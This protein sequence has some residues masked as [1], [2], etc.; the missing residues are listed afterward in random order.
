MGFWRR[1]IGG[2]KS[3]AEKARERSAEAWME[4]L[5]SPSGFERQEAVEMLGRLRHAVALPALLARLNDWVPQVRA[6]A[7]EAVR[8]LMEESVIDAWRLSLDSVVALGRARRV[9]HAELLEEI[10]EFLCRPACLGPL[11]AAGP[12]SSLVVSRYVSALEWRAAQTVADRTRLLE[13]ALSGN[14]IV[15]AREA[16]DRMPAMPDDARQRLAEVACGSRFSPVRAKGLRALLEGED[17]Q[18]GLR[19]VRRMSE[20]PHPSVR[21]IA[22]AE[23]Q[24]WGEGDAVL[25]HARATFVREDVP[26]SRRAAALRFICMADP[27]GAVESCG[28]ATLA[29][30]AAVRRVA[31]EV[32][33]NRLSGQEQ[34]RWLLAALA[35]EAAQVQRLAVQAVQRGALPPDPAHVVE[36]AMRHASA[37]ALARAFAVLRRYSLWLRLHCLLA[38]MAADLPAD[39]VQVRVAALELWE[40][41]AASCFTMP[42]RSEGERLREDWRRH[43]PALPASLQTR[44][45]WAIESAL[46]NLKG[47]G[48]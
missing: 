27:D 26:G 16:L 18:A 21:M 38:T 41:D 19:F 46:T 39:G 14:D 24:R 10:G 3:E 5:D 45:A 12:P 8:G 37:A 1:L 15:L 33:L 30:S 22:W 32:L 29:A 28:E 25:A 20:D 44:M 23:A 2:E 11:R 9:S 35:D 13:S 7:R 48:K 4:W 31:L 17:R 42:S 40:R 47:G 43:G 6:A 36:I 34:E